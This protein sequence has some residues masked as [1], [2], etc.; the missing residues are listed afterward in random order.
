MKRRI[1][2]IDGEYNCKRFSTA[3]KKFMKEHPGHEEWE[4][5]FQWMFETETD[6]FSDNFFADGTKNQDWSYA[7]HLDVYE[8]CFYLALI[9]IA[10]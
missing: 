8:E 2:D 4:E 5:T 1:T 9:E 6:F 7:L 3:L 10:A